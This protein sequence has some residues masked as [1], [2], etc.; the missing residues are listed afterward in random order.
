M[1][2]LKEIRVTGLRMFKTLTIRPIKRSSPVYYQ[3]NE[4]VTDREYITWDE[5][6]ATP[7]SALFY[8]A[9]L[10]KVKRESMLAK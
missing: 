4:M 10:A 7:E 5:V 6:F 1:A 8:I 9:K 3:I 2:E